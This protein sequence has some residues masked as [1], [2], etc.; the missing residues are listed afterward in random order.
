MTGEAGSEARGGRLMSRRDEAFDEWL[1]RHEL[2]RVP[3]RV[4]WWRVSALGV[5][6]ASA[7]A[8]LLIAWIMVSLF[9][10][11]FA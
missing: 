5:L 10:L 7:F 1:R 4:D 2:E 9:L 8:V 6:V 3:R 11:I